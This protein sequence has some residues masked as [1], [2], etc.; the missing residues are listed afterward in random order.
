MTVTAKE[1]KGL[2][3]NTWTAPDGWPRTKPVKRSL[4]IPQVKPVKPKVRVGKQ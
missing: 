4:D 3:D 2:A 1:K